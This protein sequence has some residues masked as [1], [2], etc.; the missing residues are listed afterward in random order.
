MPP[1]RSCFREARGPNW[2]WK[3]PPRRHT[4]KR[5][6]EELARNGIEVESETA[7]GDPARTIIEALRRIS[8]D[9][10]VMGTHGRA[11]V[12]AFWEGS[13]AAEVATRI[14]TPLL[15]VPLDKSRA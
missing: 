7:R 4:S 1:F 5:K 12:D 11:G 10:V 2:R 6:A 14:Q 15:L 9:L 3:V 13:V 8:A